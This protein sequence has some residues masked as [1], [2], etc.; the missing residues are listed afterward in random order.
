MPYAKR[1]VHAQAQICP[2]KKDKQGQGSGAPCTLFVERPRPRPRLMTAW[3]YN[4]GMVGL[5]L[6]WLVIT[7]CV[8]LWGRH[9]SSSP[10]R[11]LCALSARVARKF[12]VLCSIE[13]GINR[14][15]ASSVHGH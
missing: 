1:R 9:T 12:C 5:G 2:K 8:C 11:A 7:L 13:R 6:G 14:I 10:G 4:Q 3:R 15:E